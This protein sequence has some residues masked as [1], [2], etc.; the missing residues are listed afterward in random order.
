MRLPAGATLGPYE[1]VAPLGAGGMGEVYR[2]R[3]VRLGRQVALKL[4]LPDY[5]AD[6]DRLRRFR[7]EA[8]AAG[9]LNHPNVVAVFDVG[10]HEGAPYVVSELLEGETLR[11]RLREGPLVTSSCPSSTRACSA[12]CLPRCRTAAQTTAAPPALTTTP[13]QRTGAGGGARCSPW[14]DQ[15]TE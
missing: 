15:T 14:A 11:Q 10:T 1:V 7:L 5:A 4:L 3:D 8:E 6:D 13:T 12:H 9:L 2:S